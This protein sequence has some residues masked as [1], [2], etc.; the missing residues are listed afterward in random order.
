MNEEGE[1]TVK[2]KEVVE[3]EQ[4]FFFKCGAVEMIMKQL[5]N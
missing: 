1:V 5:T 4:E 3:H 2:N